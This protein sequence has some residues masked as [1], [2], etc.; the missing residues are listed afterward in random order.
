MIS[1]DIVPIIIDLVI[2]RANRRLPVLAIIN[3][4]IDN[5]GQ[6]IYNKYKHVFI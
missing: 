2:F 4:Y 3:S 5:L 1:K 6:I